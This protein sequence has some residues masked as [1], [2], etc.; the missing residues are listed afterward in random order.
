LIEKD[1]AF[2]FCGP[3]LA[4]RVGDNPGSSDEVRQNHLRRVF[5]PGRQ[6]MASRHPDIGLL[7]F[8]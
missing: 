2:F 8:R 6:L 3:H 4:S 5:P 7:I 1:V